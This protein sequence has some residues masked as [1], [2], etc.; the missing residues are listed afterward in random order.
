MRY[1]IYSIKK[2]EGGQFLLIAMRGMLYV[3]DE[4]LTP[5][6]AIALIGLKLERNKVIVAV[7]QLVI[8]KS[9]YGGPMIRINSDIKSCFKLLLL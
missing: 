7:S 1:G 3:G 6:L 5:F 8:T 9:E 4:S 2:M